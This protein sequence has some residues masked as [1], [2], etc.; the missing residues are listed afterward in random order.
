VESDPALQIEI[1]IEIGIEIAI[2]ADFDPEDGFAP[3]FLMSV[4]GA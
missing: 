3:P 2:E 1:G 4:A